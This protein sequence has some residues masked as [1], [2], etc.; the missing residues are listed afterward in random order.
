MG[1]IKQ[2]PPHEAHKIAA[3]EVVERPASVVKELVENALDAGA[4]TIAIYIKQAG[5]ELIRI[6]DDGCGMDQDD[7]ELCFTHH[8]TSK[9]K[10][11]DDLQHV[12][13]FGF[14]GEAL[15]S[16]SAVSKLTL[17][18]KQ[19]D[20]LHG[21]KVERENGINAITHISCQT[22]TD[23][24]IHD[25]FYNVPAR[26]KF[27]RADQTE[28]RNI[29][30]LFQA[31][32]FSYPAIHFKLYHDDS[33]SYNCPPTSKLINRCEQLIESS[34]AQS[35]IE[36]IPFKNESVELTGIISNHQVCRYDR[37][38][39]FFFVNN[40]WVKNSSLSKSVIKGYL[41]MLP[42]DR[43]PVVLLNIWVNPQEVDI[44]VHPRKEEVSFLHQRKI[45]LALQEAIKNSL[46]Q[47]MMP[48]KK[49][50]NMHPLL[51][52]PLEKEQ[53]FIPKTFTSQ[54]IAQKKL[55]YTAAA[56][57]PLPTSLESI[58]FNE[59]MITELPIAAPFE[60]TQQST[61]H[62]SEHNWHLLGTFA[63]TY[64][65]VE[66]HDGLMMID[67]HAAHERILYEQFKQR[68]GQ[69][70]T[71]QLL[72]PELIALSAHDSSLIVEYKDFFAQHGILLD[73]I[74]ETHIAVHSVPVHL[75]NCSQSA[76][77]K[78]T[79]ALI[80]EHQELPREEFFKKAHEKMHAQMACKA[81]V[82]AGDQLSL[83]QQQELISQLSLCENQ[84]ACPHGRPTRWIISLY[85]I[86]KKFKRKM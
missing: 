60:E 6:V 22:G 71:I 76:L 37:G 81:A 62:N 51:S 14:R 32:C 48:E 2:L 40:R 44:N 20:A 82:K 41:N 84:I 33:L 13:S 23:I 61:I 74:S 11:F 4:K 69:L 80:V 57:Q 72:F 24:A 21:I 70:P 18:T 66:R 5:K 25:L 3:G 17:I 49:V 29:V 68:F 54:P 78:E 58:P 15:T 45:E 59:E 36:L 35:M 56:W 1:K 39:L 79:I 16:I 9:L 12:T 30:Q 7:A 65:L 42:P 63:S 64:L 50:V 10:S 38:L 28:W 75:K 52:T 8:A 19:A 43:F 55:D 31:F 46:T 77:I 53:H 34:I 47:S 67:Q 27:L 85:E 83:E 73:Q 26:K 86:E